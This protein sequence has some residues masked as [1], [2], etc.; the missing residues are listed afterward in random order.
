MFNIWCNLPDFDFCDNIEYDWTDFYEEQEE[1]IPP[2]VPLPR[3]KE[4]DQ[5]M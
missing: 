5:Y 3:G 2:H 1:A 4:M